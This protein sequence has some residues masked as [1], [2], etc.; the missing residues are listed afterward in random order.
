MLVISVAI[1]NMTVT[2]FRAFLKLVNST[3]STAFT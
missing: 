3:T 2:Q 1:L